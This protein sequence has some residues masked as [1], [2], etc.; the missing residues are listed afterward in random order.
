M[1]HKYLTAKELANKLPSAGWRAG[2]ASVAY[3]SMQHRLVITVETNA[4]LEA[5]A[6]AS[7]NEDPARSAEEFIKDLG[8]ILLHFS[9]NDEAVL[10]EALFR[11]LIG[12]QYGDD[13]PAE[14]RAVIYR[15]AIATGLMATLVDV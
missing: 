1:D 11:R 10:A 12:W 15:E 4:C 14:S 7:E 6:Y 5:L 13:L 9:P 8:P 2:P 3:L